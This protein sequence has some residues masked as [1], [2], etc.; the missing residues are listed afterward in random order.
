LPKVYPSF[1]KLPFVEGQKRPLLSRL[2]SGGSMALSSPS[3]RS[4]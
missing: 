3:M 1:G 4:P 2:H